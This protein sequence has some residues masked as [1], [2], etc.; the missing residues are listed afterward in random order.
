[1]RVTAVKAILSDQDL[2]GILKEYVVVEGLK[3]EKIEINEL[4]TVYGSYKKGVLI[5]FKAQVGMGNIVDNTINLKIFNINVMKIGLLKL[6]KNLA[7]KTSLKDFYDIGIKVH[8]DTITVN[9]G[10]ISKLI[11]YVYFKLNKINIIQDAI[12]V[13]VEEVIYAQ[14]KETMKFEKKSKEAKNSFKDKYSNLRDKLEDNIPDKYEKLAEYAMIIPDIV[15][16]FY[17][18][19]KDK[20]VG[21]KNKLLIGG[22]ITYL[23]SP[24]D[25]VPDFIPFIGKIDDIA[26]AFFGLNVIINE[27]PENIILENWQGEENII[28]MVKEAVKYISQVVGAKNVNKLIDFIKGFSSKKSNAEHSNKKQQEM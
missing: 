13:E 12:E 4:I 23:A 1:M 15:V 26:I 8:K 16:L 7:L 11:P 5:H 17:R 2:L 6:I 25:I 3:F 19:F 22:I 14:N 20:R 18:L 24:I 27:L 28:L 10:T 21:I 9:L